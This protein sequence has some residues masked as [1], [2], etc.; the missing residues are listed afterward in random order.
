MMLFL[1]TPLTL[2]VNAL[3]TKLRDLIEKVVRAKLGMNLPMVMTGHSLIYEVGD[4]L[5]EDEK[6]NY[7]ANLE[8]VL[9]PVFL[10]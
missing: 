9:A 1:Q 8:K 2:E 7:E 3:R 4:D 10:L 5:D 6:R